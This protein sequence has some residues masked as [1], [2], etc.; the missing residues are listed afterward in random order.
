MNI[1]AIDTSA[2]SMTLAVR[3]AT[4]DVYREIASGR[5]HSRDIL[6][7][8][9]SLLAESGVGLQQLDALGKCQGP[10]IIHWPENSCGRGSRL[11]LWVVNS[12]CACV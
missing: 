7:N 5:K 1:L 3:T 9:L 8:I 4:D 2:S 12:C 6:P 10:R 11:S